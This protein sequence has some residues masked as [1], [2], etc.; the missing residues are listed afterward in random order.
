[1]YMDVHRSLC[2]HIPPPFPITPNP[3]DI[4]AP[5]P[6][7]VYP[8]LAPFPAKLFGKDNM[9]GRDMYIYKNGIP[10]YKEDEVLGI[11]YFLK[12]AYYSVLF[13]V[14][15]KRFLKVFMNNYKPHTHTTI[16]SCY[17]NLMLSLRLCFSQIVFSHFFSSNTTYV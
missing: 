16:S 3:W 4:P 9:Y 17:N 2:N 14:R 13:L 8:S 12:N 15:G 1:M 5:V 7:P 11:K 6:R 10:H